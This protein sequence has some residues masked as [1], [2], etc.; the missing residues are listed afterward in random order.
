M[1]NQPGKDFSADGLDHM[2]IT[3][4]GKISEAEKEAIKKLYGF[5]E[6]K[7]CMIMAQFKKCAKNG[8]TISTE[9]MIRCLRQ[10]LVPE[11]AERIVKCFDKNGDGKI[12]VREFLLMMSATISDDPIQTARGMF[13]IYDK[14]D[15]GEI[16][17]AEL[18]EFMS[19]FARS[20]IVKILN[21]L[22]KEASTNPNMAVMEFDPLKD[23]VNLSDAQKEE[24]TKTAKTIIAQFDKDKNG[25]ISLEEFID[26]CKG[27]HFFIFLK[28]IE[29]T[30]E[31]ARIDIG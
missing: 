5:S 7:Y 30:A 8:K 18:I 9:D 2:S 12:D 1:G 27:Q 15:S 31:T 10:D 29:E 3:G 16:D 20:R 21:Q 22:A 11:L 14:D 28:T 25:S 19:L 4:E 6:E 23:E 13:K 24:V 26:G 17:E